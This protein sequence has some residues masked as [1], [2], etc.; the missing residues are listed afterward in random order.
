MSFGAAR[1]NVRHTL[2]HP[3]LGRSSPTTFGGYPLPR[4]NWPC[5]CR[6]ACGFAVKQ[7]CRS[8]LVTPKRCV[9]FICVRALALTRRGFNNRD[10]P[11]LGSRKQRVT[12]VRQTD[13]LRLYAQLQVQTRSHVPP[14]PVASMRHTVAF[15]L[16]WLDCTCATLASWSIVASRRPARCERVGC[17]A[18][19]AGLQG[20]AT[21]H[22]GGQS[23]LAHARRRTRHTVAVHNGSSDRPRG[24]PAARDVERRKCILDLSTVAV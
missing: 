17:E 8:R 5:H 15:N 1:A 12:L 11:E 14:P 18:I 22:L 24:T 7:P 2:V 3:R 21:V 10:G 19:P 23:V 13:P 9:A 4:R 6:H 16:E 20:R